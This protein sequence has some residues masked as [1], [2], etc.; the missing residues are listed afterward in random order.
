[1]ESEILQELK[2]KLEKKKRRVSHTISHM[3]E[4]G[5]GESMLESIGELSAYDNHPAD[6]GDVMFERSKDIALR[7]N[8]SI[9][10]TEIETALQRMDNGNYGIC[11]ECGR[12]I[13]VE[14]LEVLPWATYCVE[15]QEKNESMD[16]TTSRPLEEEILSP[17]FKRTFLDESQLNVVGF[18]GEDALQAVLQWG[19]SD[20]PQDLPGSHDYNDLWPNSQELSMQ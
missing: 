6:L 12:E 13:D 14:R 11:K 5:L 10:L 1:M 4:D 15:C 17:P 18:D 7:D 9:L 20:T 2:Q 19:S 16:D 8:E 3:E